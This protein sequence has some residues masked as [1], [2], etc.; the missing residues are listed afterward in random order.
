MYNS[1][2][3]DICRSFYTA[4][5]AQI[6]RRHLSDVRVLSGIRLQVFWVALYKNLSVDELIVYIQVL[7]LYKRMHKIKP[8]HS[9]CLFK[10]LFKALSMSFH[11]LFYNSSFV[12]IASKQKTA[13]MMPFFVIIEQYHGWIASF[14]WQNPFII[15]MD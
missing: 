14:L 2:F 1:S 9:I 12:F 13:A 7:K 3:L 15:I 4:D 8:S 10:W 11:Q 6:F 5:V